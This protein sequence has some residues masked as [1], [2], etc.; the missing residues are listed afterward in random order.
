MLHRLQPWSQPLS[1]D[2]RLCLNSLGEVF[3]DENENERNFFMLNLSHEGGLFSLEA[4][5]E[6]LGDDYSFHQTKTVD[7]VKR[8]LET[9]AMEG[10]DTTPFVLV[11]GNLDIEMNIDNF[12]MG[13]IAENGAKTEPLSLSYF[14]C[15]RKDGEWESFEEIPDA[16]NLDAADLEQEMFRILKKF[17]EEHELSFFISNDAPRH[18]Q[19][20]V[21]EDEMER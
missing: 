21:D 5:K 20:H 15:V 16:V 10:N 1:V 19:F 8:I 17:A 11:A 4:T 6:I 12:A 7:E 13:V 14:C 9:G 2:G 18:E 3:E